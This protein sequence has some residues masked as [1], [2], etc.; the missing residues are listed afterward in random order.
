[1]GKGVGE[2]F[3]RCQKAGVKFIGLAGMLTDDV[4][5]EFAANRSLTL[6][7]IVPVLASAQQSKAEPAKYL[8]LLAS[9]GARSVASV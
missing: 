1:M 4:A 2:L 6:M 3:Q 5:Q 8:R 7:G 9:E